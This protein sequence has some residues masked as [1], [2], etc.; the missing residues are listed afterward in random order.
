MVPT[1]SKG[2]LCF[3][4]LTPD[5]S[6]DTVQSISCIWNLY[7]VKGTWSRTMCVHC[8]STASHWLDMGSSGPSHFP[9]R[10]ADTW[11]DCLFSIRLCVFLHIMRQGSECYEA[12]LCLVLVVTT[13]PL[14]TG[15]KSFCGH[16]THAPQRSKSNL[17]SSHVLTCHQSKF[18]GQNQ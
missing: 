9:L 17:T 12:A 5:V 8:M 13:L 1:I 11:S 3:S 16:L 10:H 15:L 4:S 18:S 14:R 2:Q 6:L 7:N